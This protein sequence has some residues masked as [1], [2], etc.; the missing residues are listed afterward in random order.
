MNNHVGDDLLLLPGQLARGLERRDVDVLD[1]DR[2]V[3]GYVRRAIEVEVDD[4][5]LEL[6]L[7]R[8]DQHHA[9]QFG[10]RTDRQ[11]PPIFKRLTPQPA[12]VV[13]ATERKI[14]GA[15]KGTVAEFF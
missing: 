11:H 6:I 2:P 10:I 7:D 14:A 9:G 5:I 15:A 8:I 12:V 13:I 1:H 4:L 3:V